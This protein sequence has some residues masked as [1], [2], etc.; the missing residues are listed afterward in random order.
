[1]LLD[2]QVGGVAAYTEVYCSVDIPEPEVVVAV[3]GVNSEDHLL[4]ML[5]LSIVVLLMVTGI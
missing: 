2:Q 1:M 3:D 5:K 4:A